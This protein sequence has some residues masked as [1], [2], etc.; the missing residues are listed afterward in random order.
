M[1]WVTPLLVAAAA[2]TF[3]SVLLAQNPGRQPGVESHYHYRLGAEIA[4]RTP[5]RTSPGAPWAPATPW[6]TTSGC[7]P[8]S[9]PSPPWVAL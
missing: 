5:V 8:S 7:T 2:A 4:S 1:R 9:P 3:A 6:T